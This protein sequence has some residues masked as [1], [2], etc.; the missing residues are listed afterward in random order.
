VQ[1]ALPILAQRRACLPA[2][3]SAA[4]Q[5]AIRELVMSDPSLMAD[6]QEE[7]V[8]DAVKDIMASD[9]RQAAAMK[10]MGQ[11]AVMSAVRKIQTGLAVAAADAR[12]TGGRPDGAQAA[13]SGGDAAPIKD[14]FGEGVGLDE[15]VGAVQGISRQGRGLDLTKDTPAEQRASFD[16]RMA[17]FRQI[18]AKQAEA[19][20]AKGDWPQPR[21]LGPDANPLLNTPGV[22]AIHAENLEEMAR[23]GPLGVFKRT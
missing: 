8:M 13:A 10:Y 18:K 17:A 19:A 6:M 16:A 20:A 2:D 22:E 7:G 12:E 11:P 4:E 23:A 21:E 15:L 1:L 9:D 14:P 3:T 5:A